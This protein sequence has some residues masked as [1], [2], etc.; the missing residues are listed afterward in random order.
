VGE[1]G[2]LR[3]EYKAYINRDI[4]NIFF[5]IDDVSSRGREDIQTLAVSGNGVIVIFFVDF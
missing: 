3:A 4:L 5:L 2:R 1:T